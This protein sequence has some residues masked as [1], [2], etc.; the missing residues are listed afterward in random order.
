MMGTGGAEE[1]L[2]ILRP[3]KTSVFVADH[4]SGKRQSLLMTILSSL[5]G[6]LVAMKDR[7]IEACVKAFLN[8]KIEK[9]GSVANLRIDSMQRNIC[10]H[11][12]L[13]GESSLIE[14]NVDGYEL[15]RENGQVFISCQSFR[16][17]RG[18][19]ENLLREYVAG[20]KFQLPEVARMVL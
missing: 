10:A 14:V 7:A 8:Q 11:L 6:A 12:A 2:P 13:N 20:R 16:A 5:A 4:A 17:S 19:I 9:F 1:A 3:P 15:I 18:W